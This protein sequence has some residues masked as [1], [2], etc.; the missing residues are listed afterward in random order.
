MTPEEIRQHQFAKRPLGYD[1]AEVRGFLETI[2]MALEHAHHRTGEASRRIADL[3]AQVREF[4]ALESSLRQS[5]VQAQEAGVV[6]AENGRR[7]AHALIR[8]AESRASVIVDRS[9]TELASVQEQITILRAKKDSV[10]S[11]LRMLL[12][13]EL[14]LLKALEVNA[15]ASDQHTR[16]VPP[17]GNGGQ[18]AGDID[19]ILR[20]LDAF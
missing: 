13:S 11:R 3:E 1:P 12:Q 19:E 16:A 4:Q 9:R 5:L 8:E 18:P 10:V 6:A 15:A 7:E 14:D 17:G 20:S 2:A